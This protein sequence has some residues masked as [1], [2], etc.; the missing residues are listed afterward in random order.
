MHQLH[1]E[2]RH[3]LVI[4]DNEAI[5]VDFRKILAAPRV[6]GDT[7]NRLA[8]NKAAFFGPEPSD[9][10]RDSKLANSGTEAIVR[11]LN[12][13]IECASQGQEGLEKLRAAV[14]DGRP[15]SV[16]FVDM[17]MPPGWD[18]IQT[19]QR[20]WEADPDLQVVICTAYSDNSWDDIA[21]RLG[22]SDRLL[23]LK[24]PFDP[25][26]VTQLATALSEKW[27]LR[28]AARLKMDELEKM[29]ETRT[30]ELAHVAQ[31]DKLTGLPNRVLLG[32]R[33]T[34]AVRMAQADISHK[35][36]VLFLDFDRFK[37]IN[38]SLGHD[39]GDL[40]LKDIANRLR[41][42]LQLA[43]ANGDIAVRESFAARLGGDE[44]VILL[45]GVKS[46]DDGIRFAEGLLKVLSAP[47]RLEHHDVHSSASIGITV[48]DLCYATA[49][50][51]VRDADTAM[52]QAK[53]GGKARYVVFDRT[54]HQAVAARLAMES[55]LRLSLARG[56]FLLYYQPIVDLF[57]GQLSGF[58]AL[59]RWQH[60]TRGIVSPSSFI[61]CAEEI[62]LI[63][64]LGEW[65]LAQACGQLRRWRQKY[66][67]YASL[68]I[69]VNLSTR[70]LTAP[71]IVDQVARV[72]QRESL[73]PG[74]LSLEITESAVI[75]DFETAKGILQRIRDLGVRLQI[76]DFGTGYSSLSC[77]HQFPLDGLKI[78][79][80]FISNV[81]KRRD[82]AAVVQSIVSLARNLGMK[83]TAEG[84]ETSEQVAMLQTMDC[85]LG[86][87]FYF[88]R[89]LPA[90]EAERLVDGSQRLVARAA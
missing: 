69:N 35:F 4:D 72:I 50:Q 21:V 48:S 39:V 11:R 34:E 17:R 29:V 6:S 88:A 10:I 46:I 25:V 55:E 45:D 73:E 90:A 76:D 12:F 31:H 85:E 75:A 41:T 83:I 33:L 22:L 78:D 84:I 58:E 82:Y 71:D 37:L 47:Y 24:K 7:A 89:P 18:G 70:Q 61:Q 1:P 28:C 19:I 51:A 14:R 49:D 16:A 67:K 5:H 74:A 23:I 63:I 44:F 77:L 20:L 64:P 15:F 36:V 40:L 57:S 9:M 53:A 3:I 56:E 86:Q 81:A 2:P 80:S 30:R 54:M 59:V 42:S 62:G 79:R 60:P 13:Q 38:D 68:T 52:Y 43:T 32:E 8:G 27:S 87:G 65:I 66:P 26:E